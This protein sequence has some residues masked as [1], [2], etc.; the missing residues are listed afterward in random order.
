MGKYDS[1][2]LLEASRK[3]DYST[4]EKILNHHKSKKSAFHRY[5]H[6]DEIY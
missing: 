3:G 5:I 1:G 6:C 2:E 4:V